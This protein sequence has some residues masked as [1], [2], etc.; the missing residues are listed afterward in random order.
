MSPISRAGL[1]NQWQDTTIRGVSSLRTIGYAIVASALLCCGDG[2]SAAVSEGR[3]TD[4]DP[5]RVKLEEMLTSAA[6]P[7]RHVPQPVIHALAA[8]I[9]G[10]TLL[11]L[12]PG[13]DGTAE[14][15]Y[16]F[17][18]EIVRSPYPEDTTAEEWLVYAGN[19]EWGHLTIY[20]RDKK[21][22]LRITGQTWR[23]PLLDSL[24]RA[25]PPTIRVLRG[26]ELGMRGTLISVDGLVDVAGNISDEVFHRRGGRLERLTSQFCGLS[27]RQRG[28]TRTEMRYE[29]IDA[30]GLMEIGIFRAQD[31]LGKDQTTRPALARAFKYN[32]KELRFVDVPTPPRP[33]GQ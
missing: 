23:V 4:T 22:V 9:P 5:N 31:S 1:D 21:E 13:A 24:V 18:M 15:D 11:P 33:S 3:T 7:V 26:A 14:A 19:G 20:R 6:S 16:S 2:Q 27:R 32:L 12:I 17:V 28:L 10:S 29:D 8:S 30:D 25:A